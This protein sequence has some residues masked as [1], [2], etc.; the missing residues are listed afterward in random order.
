V[1]ARSLESSVTPRSAKSDEQP[2]RRDVVMLAK[3]SLLHGVAEHNPGSQPPM[4]PTNDEVGEADA[5]VMMDRRP[6]ELRH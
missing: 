4:G 3:A 5:L 6:A 2:P 1:L